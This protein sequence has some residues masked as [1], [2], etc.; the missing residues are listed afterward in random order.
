MTNQ[1]MLDIPPRPARTTTTTVSFGILR[2]RISESCK[3]FQI[4][5]NI[6]WNLSPFSPIWL[7]HLLFHSKRHQKNTD[8]TS[9]FHVQCRSL[10]GKWTLFWTKWKWLNHQSDDLN[11]RCQARAIRREIRW[12]E[13]MRAGFAWNVYLRGLLVQNPTNQKN[14]GVYI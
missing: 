1:S 8:C 14:T 2:L 10:V 3:N 13:G 7:F 9:A 12:D 5:R 6:S 11:M 4:S